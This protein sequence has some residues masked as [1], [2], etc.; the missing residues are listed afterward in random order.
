VSVLPQERVKAFLAC[1]HV[2]LG[3]DPHGANCGAGG[4]RVKYVEQQGSKALVEEIDP[5]YGDRTDCVTVVG[6]FEGQEA[7][8]RG[9]AG[10]TTLL[11]KLQGHLQG[12]LHRS[13]AVV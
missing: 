5:A 11:P 13:R 1:S 2:V 8:L 7:L 4:G 3:A 6:V 12:D 10:V 9:H